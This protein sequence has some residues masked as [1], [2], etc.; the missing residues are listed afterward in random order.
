[1][2]RIIIA[3]LLLSV[4][5]GFPL[6][7]ATT[8]YEAMILDVTNSIASVIKDKSKVSFVSVDCESEDFAKRLI[9][10][11][12]QRLINSDCIVLDRSNLDSIIAELE[13]Q[14]S[15]LVDEDQSVS[16][17]HMLGADMIIAASAENMVSSLHVD[18]QLIDLETTLVK[19]H[20]SYDL[21]YDTQLKNIVNGSTNA[22]GNQRIGIGLR[23]GSSIELNKAHEDMVGTG[24]VRPTEKSPIGFV[25]TLSAFYRL[26][27][28]LKVQA[29]MSYFMNN[30]IKVLGFYDN[31]S[32]YILDIDVSYTSLDIPVMLSFNFIQKPL[33]VDVYAGA[34]VSIPVSTANI[35]YDIE[36]YGTLRGAVD[37]TGISFGVLGGL[38]VGFAM[39]PGN[40]VLDAR[41]LYDLTY[42]KAQGE[43]LGPGEQGLIYRKGVV[44]SAGY[45]FEL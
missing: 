15:G 11:V 6:F 31:Y 38:D 13:F 34:Y 5:V 36:G 25:P 26:N 7:A 22:I 30:G 12:E 42:S 3:F 41:F 39:G 37:V 10:D 40:F 9:T 44:C 18:I 27:E 8:T 21:K 24:G 23:F 28:S 43:I 4:V 45:V 33:N 19:R 32:G 29:E 17:G 16:I 20:L 1:M 14:T 2:K 35:S